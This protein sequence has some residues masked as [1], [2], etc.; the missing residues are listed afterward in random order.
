M[1][2]RLRASAR[3]RAHHAVLV[4]NP[5]AFSGRTGSPADFAAWVERGLSRTGGVP[6]AW[7]TRI[8]VPIA[9]PSRVAVA[10]H[11]HFPE[12]ADEVLDSLRAIPV[13]FDLIVTNSSGTTLTI[14][15]DRV[16]NACTVVV[17][18]VENRG[19]DILPLISLVNAGFL[20]AYHLILKVHT[21]RSDWRR[22][23]AELPGTGAAWRDRLL[24][25]LLGDAANVRAIIGAFAT[26]PDLGLVTG[27]GSL[28]HA[29]FW[30]DNQS[31]AANLL[32]RLELEL[33]PDELAFAAGS[34]YWT[35][36]FVLQGLRALNLT[37][38]DFEEEAGQVNATTA[39]AVERIIGIIA[40]E[41]GLTVTERSALPPSP[42]TSAE[43]ARFDPGSRA[44][45]PRARLVPFYLPQFHPIEQN[46]RWWG[47]GFTEWSNVA[48]ARPVYLGH[49]QPK[50]PTDTGFYD[51]RLDDTVRLQASMARDAGVAGL[52]YYHYWFA[53]EELLDGPIRARLTGDVDLPFCLMWANE[54]WTRRWDGRESDVLMGQRYE[55]VSAATFIEAVLPI[56]RDPRYLRIDGRPILAIYRPAQIPRVAT[57]I[58][59]WREAARRDGIGE[60]LL[61]NVDVVKDFDGIDHTIN[62][63]GLDGSLGFPPH[64]ALWDWLPHQHVGAIPGFGGN[65]LSYRALVHDAI[66]KLE[67]GIPDTFYPGVMVDFDNTAR[68]QASPDVWFGANPY[69]FRRWLAA[70]VGSIAHRDPEHRVVFINAWNEWAEGA[71]LEPSDRFGPTFLQAVRDV[72]YG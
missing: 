9:S 17:L 1:L 8:D 10:M 65:I 44:L 24:G 33:Q 7:R 6:D 43:W 34:M 38:T 45:R 52:M 19:R 67:S 4:V 16:P 54:N 3:T 42:T 48:A 12:L 55:D 22:D 71:V 29:E 66:R 21:K 14:D 35:R 41:A 26:S 68:R 51:L 37:P 15:P 27:D 50:L 11:V 62:D 56:L 69:T 13:P 59:A 39:H 63:W 20:D 23:H 28:L 31:V 58:A 49:H 53:G 18:D 46:D 61:L 2:S 64:N 47:R 5:A 36:G 30:G 57:A 60:L 70:A 40:H 32:R 25:D 72:A